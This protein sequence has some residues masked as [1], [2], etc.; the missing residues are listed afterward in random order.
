MLMCI[1]EHHWTHPWIPCIRPSVDVRGLWNKSYTRTETYWHLHRH[2]PSR[3]HRKQGI[4]KSLWWLSTENQRV[5][6][7]STVLSMFRTLNDGLKGFRANLKP[8][9]RPCKTKIQLCS[10]TIVST[11]M[12]LEG[13]RQTDLIL[14]SLSLTNMD[15]NQEETVQ[16]CLDR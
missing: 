15:Q 16:A 1:I 3:A 9:N 10:C 7:T 8:E 4:K 11:F 5:R 12:W 14:I 6:H 2:N 13:D